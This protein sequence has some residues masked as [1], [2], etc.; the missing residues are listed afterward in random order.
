MVGAFGSAI[1]IERRLDDDRIIVALNPGVVDS[2]LEVAVED[3]EHGWLSLV[4]LPGSDGLGP[5]VVTGSSAQVPIP[6]RSARLLRVA[7]DAN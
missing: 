7:R 4:E 5:I 1:A 2:D 3:V 6:A